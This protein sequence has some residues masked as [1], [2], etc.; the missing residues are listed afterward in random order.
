MTEEFFNTDELMFRR[1]ENKTEWN[2]VVYQLNRPTLM[3][4]ISGDTIVVDNLTCVSEVEDECIDMDNQCHVS[5]FKNA[6]VAVTYSG[7]IVQITDEWGDMSA[8]G[9]VVFTQCSI[10]S[11]LDEKELI[12]YLIEE[13]DNDKL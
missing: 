12:N 2:S 10:H 1:T 13:Q 9:D 3:S 5:L 4:T 11:P 7:D 8:V 6:I